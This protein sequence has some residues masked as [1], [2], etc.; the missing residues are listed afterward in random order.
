MVIE[1]KHGGGGFLSCRNTTGIEWKT[2]LIGNT[3]K[4]HCRKEVK[5]KKHLKM[6]RSWQENKLIKRRRI[7]SD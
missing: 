1:K 6:R 4:G 2:Q 5:E 3:K 7:D